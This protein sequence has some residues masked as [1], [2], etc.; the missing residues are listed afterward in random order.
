MLKVHQLTRSYGGKV[1][2]E[3]LSF[4]LPQDGFN[5]LLGPNDAGKPALFQVLT[6]LFAADEGDVEVAGLWMRR[7][8]RQALAHIG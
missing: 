3:A 4:A 2:L 5:A 6:D 1:A 8:A 7:S